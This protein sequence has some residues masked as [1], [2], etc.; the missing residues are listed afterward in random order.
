MKSI[1]LPYWGQITSIV[2]NQE[3]R[4]LFITRQQSPV[5]YILDNKSDQF[6]LSSLKLPCVMQLLIKDAS[7]NNVLMFGADGHLYQSDWQAKK[8]HKISTISLLDAVNALNNEHSQQ[9]TYKSQ[10]SPSSTRRL[11]DP[12]AI[13]RLADRS[14]SDTLAIIYP[15]HIVIWRYQNSQADTPIIVEPL[16]APP[17][18]TNQSPNNRATAMAASSDGNWLVVGD[19]LGFVSSYHWSSG[20]DSSN[21]STAH[22]HNNTSL[23][24]SSRQ[25]IHQGAITALCFEPI[26]QYF[27]SAGVD[28]NLYRTH[29]QGDLQPIDRAKA[30]QHSQ[31]ITALC[32]SDTRLFSAADDKSIKSWPFDK[33]GAN[34]CKEDLN[35]TRLLALSSY[36]ERSALIAVGG[37]QSL[38][39]IPIQTVTDETIT[40]D[41][42]SNIQNQKLLP[43]AYIIKDGYQKITELLSERSND[44]AIAFNEGLALLNTQIDNQTLEIVNQLLT[45]KNSTITAHQALQLIA[46][47]AT[48][49]LD[50]TTKVLEQLLNSTISAQARLAAFHALAAKAL[51]AERPLQYLERALESKHE[52][53]VAS[54]I[55]GYA[56]V[57]SDDATSLR[58][59]ITILQQ[60]LAHKLPRIRKQALAALESLLPKDSPQADL[61][62]LDAHYPDVIQAG[63][64]RLYQ[65][66]MLDSLEVSRQLMR[67]KDHDNTDV[68]QSAFYISVLSQSKL[69]HAL[70]QQA[71]LQGDTQLLRTMSDF[72]GF[73]LLRGTLLDD[74][75]NNTAEKNNDNAAAQSDQAIHLSLSTQDFVTQ[76]Q[77][78][79]QKIKTGNQQAKSSPA[80]INALS[81]EDLEP[82]L[83]SL[84]NP[85]E[86]ISFRA[87][88]ALACLQDK[89]A[90]GTLIRLMHA[91]GDATIRAGVATA[92][93]NLAMEEGKAVLPVLLDDKEASVRVVAMQAFGKLADSALAWAAVGF[94]ASHQDIHEQSLAIF[95]SQANNESNKKT[96]QATLMTDQMSEILLQALNNPFTSIRLEVVKVLLNR[97]LEPSSITIVNTIQ[98]LQQSLFEDVHQVA[99]EEWQRSLLSSKAR[100]QDSIT[101]S[102]TQSVLALFLADNFA[103]I[104]KQA[105]DIALKNTKRLSFNE[106]ITTALACPYVDTKQLALTTLQA[107]ASI[108]QLKSLL[109]VLVGMLADD[110]VEL[111]QQA[112]S[113]AL[114]LTDLQ[115]TDL[116]PIN[117]A[118]L[119]S[120]SDASNNSNSDAFI[121]AALASPY[122]DIQLKVAQL[123]A[124][125]LHYDQQAYDVFAHYLAIDMPTQDK[126]SEAYRQWHQHITQA[127]LGLAQLS[128]PS[129]HPAKDWY[130]KYLSHPDANFSHLAPKLMFICNQ[131]DTDI[132]IKW[133]KDERAIVSQSA[134]LALAV[135]G[136]AL[137]QHFF[138]QTAQTSKHF[139]NLAKPL[140]PLNWMQAQQGLGITHARQLRALFHSESYAPAAR[141]LLI[142][143]DL[144]D[145]VINTG[146]TGTEAPQRPQRLIEALSFA[147]NETAVVYAN[148]LARYPAQLQDGFDTVWQYLSDYLTRTVATILSAHPTVID[149]L[150]PSV[151]SK[152]DSN[153]AKAHK[154]DTIRN[155]IL[156]NISAPK[157]R[158]LATMMSHSQPLLQAQAVSVIAHLSTLLS[159]NSFDDDHEVLATLQS[160]QRSL[161]SLFSI[162]AAN[163]PVAFDELAIIK[164]GAKS[165]SPYQTLA[166]GAWLG[167]IGESDGYHAD[168]QTNQAIRAL[169]WLSTQDGADYNWS[170][171]VSR[172][173][174]PLLNHAH[175]DSR[176]LAWSSL[177][178]LNTPI[179]KLTDYAMSTPHADMVK[180]GLQLRLTSL[181]NDDEDKSDVSDI[182]SAANKQLIKLL[183]TNNQSLA[184]ETYA[185]LK[186]RL[187]LL[188]ASLA[189]LDSYCDTLRYQVI[190]E[191]QH[192]N[193]TPFAAP[194]SPENT[195]KN[196]QRHDKLTFLRRAIHVDSWHARYYA[197]IQLMDFYDVLFSDTSV[198]DAVF[199]FWR[200]SQSWSD[201]NQAFS[202]LISALQL[203]KGVNRL[204]T[205]KVATSDFD[206]GFDVD[207]V[208]VIDVMAAK[209]IVN[210][211]YSKLLTLVDSP[212]RK[213]P[214]L[215]IYQGIAK[216]R[217]TQVVAELLQRLRQTFERSLN[218]DKSERQQIFDALVTISG[219]DQPIEDYWDK[220]EDKGWL[221][222]QHPR[223]P[224]VL[225]SLFTTLMSGSD[226]EHASQL[227]ASLSWAKASENDGSTPLNSVDTSIEKTTNKALSI[228]AEI[229]T[230][231]A[232]AYEQLPAKYTLQLVQTL[233]YRAE[234][235]HGSLNTLQKALLNKDADVQFIAAEGLARCGQAQGLTILM[236]TIDYNP[237]GEWRRRSVLAI[238]KLMG[239]PKA[240]SSAADSN[241]HIY[242]LYQAYDKLITLAE[243]REHY[244]QD[245]AGEALGRLGQNSDFKHSEH[246]FELLKSRLL[247]PTLAAYNPAAS[248][249]LN[250]LRWLNTLA[251]WEQIRHYIRRYMQEDICFA[252]Q[253]HAIHL[254]QFNDSDA[255]KAL[256]LD[257]LSQH[258]IDDDAALKAYRAAQKLWGNSA[259]HVYPY[260][261]ATIQNGN[262]YFLYELD[263]LSLKRIVAHAS[264]DELITF[265]N[266][267]GEHLLANILTSLQNAF[268]SRT[269]M[270]KSQLIALIDSAHV[271][272]QDIGLRYLAQYPADYLD[273]ALFKS[274]QQRFDSATRQWQALIDTVNRSPIAVS[275]DQW[276]REVAQVAATIK[277]LVWLI[278]RYLPVD[279][280][281]STDKATVTQLIKI[282][283]WLNTMCQLSISNSV[284]PLATAISNY[285][286][287]ALLALLA[288]PLDNDS[289]LSTVLPILQMLSVTQSQQLTHANHS[290]LTILI[291]RL[292]HSAKSSAT[293][294]SNKE[295]QAIGTIDTSADNRS[296]SA[297]QQ[298]LL[299]IKAKD[300]T[301]L[302]H[303][304]IHEDTDSSVRVRAIE[305]LGQL[306]EPKIKQW[307]ESLMQDDPDINND[308]GDDIA[309][310]AYKVL[311]RW[312][313][314]M[315]RAQKK[316]P[317]AFA[318]AEVINSQALTAL[319][320]QDAGDNK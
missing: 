138:T 301:A 202:L 62:A 33:G 11:I 133:Q 207:V 198:L 88:Y 140:T 204:D 251:A 111:R 266:Q 298:L 237:D 94:A 299:W 153:R 21:E 209:L 190:R 228:D 127:L 249:W 96:S 90:L 150:A 44:S 89:R 139:S 107:K 48:T 200:D 54:A 180:R 188:P 56:Q 126:D 70:K 291:T 49:E 41:A 194:T 61:F 224:Q 306:H 10:H 1:A 277:Q 4:S 187:G 87:A 110:S 199:E 18:D 247:D 232:Q 141:L 99:I 118:N 300:A 182:T 307:L 132:L 119:N 193:I 45:T 217:D 83:Q 154:T 43:V 17:V 64:I 58:R 2:D 268:M 282:I 104:R 317:S 176:E 3:G 177:C 290:L 76:T 162:N 28:K 256:L 6:S 242:A 142:F 215:E 9:L 208:D 276:R 93:G 240:S 308:N 274:L 185:L 148:I 105:F 91:D 5:L 214:K 129:K 71:H 270:S 280:D 197:F 72:D 80:L 295:V 286:Q 81:N 184:E 186:Q 116:L 22:S 312:Q 8:T 281:K 16:S 203:Y 124:G 218:N 272:S 55:Q 221:Q 303:C 304:A 269:D 254:L 292:E 115:S 262:E 241:A 63:L 227:L 311:R 73:Q 255:N 191:W 257:L 95:L 135:W 181:E 122:P 46:W 231:L 167:V 316:R 288:R 285:W 100:S 293:A 130:T 114:L 294:K 196:K 169:M 165:S 183:K 212:Q 264:I 131:D 120:T 267:Y 157:L 172:V 42:Q 27:F 278:C 7:H 109:P 315:V 229:D 84:A 219:Y 32:V 173:L 146:N 13:S 156:A 12:I 35:K 68:R 149:S 86:D 20:L 175:F 158:Q 37:D 19:K 305:A 147:D 201:Q 75:S 236:A 189:G 192:V 233:A 159:H 40:G 273:D 179:T 211:T 50:K 26:S 77:S 283:D 253:S 318:S 284:L 279:T 163:E 258:N 287:Q 67:L 314:S 296:V 106:I 36:A 275:N 250:G 313:R 238:G 30:S 39:L 98:L 297:N 57:A 265:I 102:I 223:Q 210:N 243:D 260:D 161:Q 24:L 112:L 205:D 60:T 125:Q 97:V 15:K 74:A 29:V 136:D 160:W 79:F 53:I 69:T 239:E 226:Y 92:L 244:L 230:Q 25:Q 144:Q 31:M 171:S 103:A 259:D 220:N 234:R 246:I 143:N 145:S 320:T 195:I 263:H 151:N 222:R 310:L 155:A 309:K 248:H 245:V 235:R 166:F 59:I 47:V 123:L 225:L 319:S 52:E 137:G 78:D 113:V 66:D 168:N 65:R 178:Q 164:E 85:H 82:L 38:R 174:L 23:K 134:S 170:D 206:D 101:Q 14:D 108:D 289:H 121:L 252:P 213:M 34:T 117:T 152:A 261:W 128:D 216:L 271:H 51:S 302:Y